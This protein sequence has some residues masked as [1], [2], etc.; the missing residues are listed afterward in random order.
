[1]QSYKEYPIRCKTC[2][3]QLAAFAPQYEALLESIVEEDRIAQIEALAIGGNPETGTLTRPL[4][5]LNVAEKALNRLGITEWC[6]RI[7]M[8]NPTIVT[9]NME[10]RAVIE[11]FENVDAA[12]DAEPQIHSDIQPVFASCKGPTRSLQVTPTQQAVPVSVVQAALQTVSP[13]A[14][15]AAP[16]TSPG[17]I[18]LAPPSQVRTFPNAPGAIQIAMPSQ[19]R[20]PPNVPGVQLATPTSPG[21]IQIAAPSQ[22]RT[23]PGLQALGMPMMRPGMQTIELQRPAAPI[24]APSQP[25]IQLPLPIASPQVEIPTQLPSPLG[26][27]QPVE[28]INLETGPINVGIAE[29]EVFKEPTIVGVPTINVSEQPT[30]LIGVGAGAQVIVLTGRTYLAR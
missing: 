8:M 27:I 26:A 3:E 22:L 7:A 25:A 21:V 17:L 20:T 1:M 29:T 16:S 14:V 23:V 30:T 10:N 24:A 4:N 18:Q 2:G 15:V 19:V 5:E 6:S 12:M 11:G 28:A 9:F 13:A